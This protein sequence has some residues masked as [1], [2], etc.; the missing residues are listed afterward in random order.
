MPRMIGN[1]LVL[2]DKVAWTTEAGQEVIV[3]GIAFEIV[4]FPDFCTLLA[5]K[6]TGETAQDLV[7]DAL[8]LLA[9]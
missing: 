1:L 9:Q 6:S 3:A 8:F 2:L 4:R 5:L 7:F